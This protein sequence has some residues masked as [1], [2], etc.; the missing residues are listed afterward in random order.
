M[1]QNFEWRKN[2]RI[3]QITKFSSK[4]MYLVASYIATAMHVA[5]WLAICE[6]DMNGIVILF[7]FFKNR[8]QIL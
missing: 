5:L 6:H 7:S 8:E 1:I 3:W 2:W 4:N